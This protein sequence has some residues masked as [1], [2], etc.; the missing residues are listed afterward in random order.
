MALHVAPP[1]PDQSQHNQ[2]CKYANTPL[3]HMFVPCLI[4]RTTFAFA[5]ICRGIIHLPT[6]LE[7]LSDFPS[8]LGLISRSHFQPG[9]KS[10]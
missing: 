10:L 6:S 8:F 3:R 7:F 2:G 5:F 1:Q 4:S 9:D